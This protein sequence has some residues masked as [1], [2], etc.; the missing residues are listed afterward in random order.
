MEPLPGTSQPKLLIHRLL[1]FFRLSSS[2]RL[3]TNTFSRVTTSFS[4]GAQICD[5]C[6]AGPEERA[7]SKAKRD[8]N[9]KKAR[10]DSTHLLES[11]RKIAIYIAV[12]G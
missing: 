5:R 3:A 7:V 12:K 6:G 2:A 4:L 10:A 9:K 8:E 11:V 1:L